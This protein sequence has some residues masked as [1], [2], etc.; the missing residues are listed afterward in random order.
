MKKPPCKRPYNY[1]R[2]KLVFDTRKIWCR[3]E[4]FLD[5]RT[6]CKLLFYPGLDFKVSVHRRVL[7]IVR[8]GNCTLAYDNTSK[9]TTCT[10]RLVSTETNWTLT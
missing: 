9:V 1:L 2:Q 5:L 3:R 6:K 4:Y 7:V 8:G 10:A